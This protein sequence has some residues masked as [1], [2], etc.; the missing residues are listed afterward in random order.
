MFNFEP[1]PKSEFVNHVPDKT[2]YGYDRR[3]NWIML[4]LE[5]FNLLE[6]TSDAAFT[7]WVRFVPGTEPRE[8]YLNTARRKL[9]TIRAI[10]CCREGEPWAPNPVVRIAVW[11]PQVVF[12]SP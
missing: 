1:F 7:A 2:I 6:R 4:E 9:S 8:S 11:K 3:R 10:R 5:I 12:H